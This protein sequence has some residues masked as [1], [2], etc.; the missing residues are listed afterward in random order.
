[1][2]PAAHDWHIK[3]K[4]CRLF[5]RRLGRIFS[6]GC[7]ASHSPPIQNRIVVRRSPSFV[8]VRLV[9]LHQYVRFRRSS[10]TGIDA[11]RE[12]LVYSPCSVRARATRAT[13]M[14]IAQ[15][16]LRAAAPQVAASARTFASAAASKASPKSANPSLISAHHQRPRIK[17]RAALTRRLSLPV[18][19][20]TSIPRRAAAA[21]P[22]TFDL[23][24]LICRDDWY[25]STNEI[26]S[27]S[28]RHH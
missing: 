24:E 16:A 5:A 1:M 23:C 10:G 17:L 12:C 7:Q 8:A 22:T 2:T 18:R 21:A 13:R 28:L 25:R 4:F 9:V 26:G 27:D 11:R 3:R 19:S 6:Q 14:R 20:E 15:P